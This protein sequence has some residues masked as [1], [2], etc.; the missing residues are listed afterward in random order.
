[1]PFIMEWVMNALQWHLGALRGDHSIAVNI[2]FR[3]QGF[4][5]VIHTL[6]F[7]LKL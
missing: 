3:G 1:M 5:L 7:W 2:L 4:A 6:C